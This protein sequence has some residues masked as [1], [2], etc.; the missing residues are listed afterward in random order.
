[1][2]DFTVQSFFGSD[3]LLTKISV[4]IDISSLID[5]SWIY[6]I[7]IFVYVN[8]ELPSYMPYLD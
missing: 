2:D 3:L 4:V 6:Q 8:I 1:M 5:I 7:H